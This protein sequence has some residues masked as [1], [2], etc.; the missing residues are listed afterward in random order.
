[1]GAFFAVWEFARQIPKPQK[2]GLSAT[3]PRKRRCASCGLS[4]AIPLRSGN[5][6]AANKKS[7]FK[8]QSQ[9]SRRSF[10]FQISFDLFFNLFDFAVPLFLYFPSAMLWI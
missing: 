1:L 4:A 9:I 7:K 8:P 10:C 2:T 6:I 5:G 3:S